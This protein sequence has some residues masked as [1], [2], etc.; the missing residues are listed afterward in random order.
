MWR[1]CRNCE[2]PKDKFPS[3]AIRKIGYRAIWHGQKNWNGV[4]ILSRGAEPIETRCG[5]P[6]DL[7]S[8]YIEVEV[9]GLTIG[10]IYL[11]NGNPAPG[12]KFGS[13]LL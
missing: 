4:A 5:L 12:S 13:V 9:D 11:P 3:D 7:H 6:G 10:S 2:R 8:R 1:A